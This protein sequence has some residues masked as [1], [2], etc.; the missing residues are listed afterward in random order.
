MKKKG[1]FSYF[2]NGYYCFKASAERKREINSLFIS[3]FRNFEE[4]RIHK[5][6]L[7]DK[8]IDKIFNQILKKM[9]EDNVR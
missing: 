7:V 1:E 8:A 9:Y 2:P 5:Q 3:K 6:F 4:E